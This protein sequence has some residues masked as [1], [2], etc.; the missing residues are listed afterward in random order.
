MTAHRRNVHYSE[1]KDKADFQLI[2]L[3]ANINDSDDSVQTQTMLLRLNSTAQFYTDYDRCIDLIKSN[4]DEKVLFIASRDFARIA[5]PHIHHLRSIVGVFIFDT[6]FEDDKSLENKYAKIVG[7]LSD[8]KSL[9]EYLHQTINLLEKQ[10]KIFTLFDQRQSTSRDVSKDSASFLWHQMLLRVL[11]QMPQDEQ[12]KQDMLDKCE[13]Y[14]QFEKTQ[15]KMIEKIQKKYTQ[16]GPIEW[17]KSDC[18]LHKLINRALRSE[19]IELLYSFRFFIIDLCLAIENNRLNDGGCLKLYR[20][21]TI[22]VEELEKFKQNIGNIISVN[23]FFSTTRDINVAL[24]FTS[25]AI[26]TNNFKSVLFEICADPSLKTTVFADVGDYCQPGDEQEILFNLNSLFEILAV[27]FNS[28]YQMWVIQLQTTDKGP[29]IIE[30][31]LKSIEEGMN[32]HSPIIYF[33]RLLLYELGQI[34]E[35]ETYFNK[36]LELLPSDHPDIASVYDWIGVVHHKRSKLSIGNN[37]TTR[38]NLA[39][40]NYEKAYTIRRNLLPHDHRHIASS[41]YDFANIA[42]ERGNFGEAIS[43]CQQALNIDE[44]T[45]KD[46]HEHKAEIIKKI[47]IL[48]R[49]QGDFE[50]SLKYIRQA[51]DIFQRKLPSQHPHIAMCLRSIGE[52]YLKQKE[53]DTALDYFRQKLEMDEKCSPPD[54]YYL[55]GDLDKIVDT[56]KKKG[57]I[58]SAIQFCQKKLDDQEKK[59]GRNHSRFAQTLMTTAKTLAHKNIDEALKYYEEALL[60]LEQSTTADFKIMNDCL[61]SMNN[62]YSKQRISNDALQRF[63][64]GFNLFCRIL[65]SDHIN[66][67]NICKSIALCYQCMNN[68]NQALLYFNKSLSIYQTNYGLTHEKVKDIETKILRLQKQ[69]N[70]VLNTIPL[71]KNANEE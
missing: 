9:M 56:Y 33:G 15:R 60:I 26:T 17:Y 50:N 6:N 5:L 12:S 10:A 65:P 7:V 58:D 57:D 44:K 52:V 24:A 53:F 25:S 51:L 38:L 35:A 31:N 71:Q 19:N 23:G 55:T 67:G 3:D 27:T 1:I 20:G 62:I 43:F 39:F 34:D 41:L 30:E 11:Q 61:A 46:D 22:S 54:H 48:Y 18:F 70:N 4:K 21:Q 37:K 42:E 47:G 63:L 59:F 2:W 66:I 69:Q 28:K 32:Y 64:K 49:K 40:E 16:M 68:P 14:Y 29:A 8:Q 13:N 45:Y 36:L